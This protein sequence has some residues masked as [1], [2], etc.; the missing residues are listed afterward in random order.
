[1]LNNVGFCDV[2]CHTLG[3]SVSAALSSRL[4]FIWREA[5]RFV[6]NAQFFGA[7]VA[8]LLPRKLTYLGVCRHLHAPTAPRRPPMTTRL[9]Y[10]WFL[11]VILALML[12]LL[13]TRMLAL[14]SL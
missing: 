9:Y 4:A 6:F 13:T 12:E 8:S 7:D 2:A 10:V 3:H 14:L 11:S 1:M 5:F